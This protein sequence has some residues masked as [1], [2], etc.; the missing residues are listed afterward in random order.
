MVCVPLHVSS[1]TSYFVLYR[2][3]VLQR[4]FNWDIEKVSQGDIYLSFISN[5]NIMI[6]LLKLDSSSRCAYLGK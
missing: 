5:H 6:P 3:D 2:G 4:P 1:P